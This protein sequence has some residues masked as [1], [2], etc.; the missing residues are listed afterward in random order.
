[1]KTLAKCL[2]LIPAFVALDSGAQPITT[3]STLGEPGGTYNANSGWLV[4][5]AANP[6]R[7]KYAD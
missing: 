4:N 1:M 5:G 3:Y 6:P 2:F 7:N